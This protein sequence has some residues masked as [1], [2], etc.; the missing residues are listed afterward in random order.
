MVPI[1]NIWNSNS[2]NVFHIQLN[3]EPYSNGIQ[4]K[5]AK[6]ITIEISKKRTEV[7]FKSIHDF[8]N[9]HKITITFVHLFIQAEQ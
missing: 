2:F 8:F 6:R 5:A 4:N 9:T 1:R 7:K 3:V